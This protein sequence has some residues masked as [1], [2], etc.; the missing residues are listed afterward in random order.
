MLF[1]FEIL[2]SMCLTVHQNYCCFPIL[3]LCALV[4]CVDR[5]ARGWSMPVEDL[6]ERCSVPAASGGYGVSYNVIAGRGTRDYSLC[7]IASCISTVQKLQM[8]S[9]GRLVELTV[10]G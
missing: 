5:L 3:L 8:S 10:V 7:P 9:R 4:G 2:L 6:H 1:L